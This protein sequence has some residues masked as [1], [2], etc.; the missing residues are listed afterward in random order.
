MI[1]LLKLKCQIMNL[2]CH[3]V[4]APYKTYCDLDFGNKKFISK[5]YPIF[6]LHFDLIIS[7][8][9]ETITK[10]RIVV[11]KLAVYFWCFK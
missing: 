1:L 10:E 3:Y 5:F 8:F 11:N 9:S 6:H 2:F 4:G 7:L